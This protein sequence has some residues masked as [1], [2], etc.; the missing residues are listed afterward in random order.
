MTTD[1]ETPIYRI[2]VQGRVD[3]AWSEW[4]GGLDIT[5]SETSSCPVT[6][7]IGPLSDQSMLHGVLDT[8]FMLNLPVLRVELCQAGSTGSTDHPDW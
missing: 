8:L 1:I 7:L 5:L 6:T 3:P 2:I 4:L